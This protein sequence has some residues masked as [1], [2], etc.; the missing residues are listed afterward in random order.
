MPHKYAFVLLSLLMTSPMSFADTLREAVEDTLHTHPEVSAAINSRLSAEQDMRSAEGGY[1]PNISVNAGIGKENTDSASTRAL[2]TDSDKLNRRESSISLS[3]MVF[4]GFATSSE[5]GRQKAT[6]NSR[7]YKVLNTSESRAL[8]AIQ[9]YLDVL[10]RQEYVRLAEANLL[11]HERIY[12]QIKLRTEQG[13][14]RLADLEQAQARLAQARNNALTEK[15]NLTDSQTT[16]Y[17]TIGKEPENLQIPTQSA[18]Q[19]PDSLDKARKIMLTNSPILKSAEADIIATEKQYQASKAGFYPRVNIELSRSMGDNIDGA[20]GTDN[21][22]QAMLRMR[23]NLYEGGSTEATMESKAYQVKEAQ[24]VRN[25]TL[26]L[27]N[28]ELRLAWSAV[29]NARQQLP[30]A[31]EYAERSQQVRN[32]YQKQFSLGERTLLDVLDSENELFTAQRRMVEIRFTEM[33]SE[34]RLKA[35]MGNLLASLSIPAPAASQSLSEVKTQVE[36]PSLN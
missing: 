4:D 28:E 3:Q 7:A 22:W 33:F 31:E 32:A 19:L 23:Y 30:I 14:G 9:A 26:R 20:H 18:L 1:L 16:Y 36:L 34:Y 2:G 8:D 10:Q 5:V 6:V 11:S 24:D 17:S 13:V 29:N 15:T 27:L 35:R 21:E 12:D 25:N